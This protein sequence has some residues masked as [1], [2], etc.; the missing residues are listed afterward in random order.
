MSAIKLM[1]SHDRQT[2]RMS[3]RHPYC[4]G[5][6]C[7]T[8]GALQT[9]IAALG[10]ALAALC[11][12]ASGSANANEA[13]ARAGAPIKLANLT[14]PEA[15]FAH[16]C[17]TCH[18]RG[19]VAPT[20]SQ[21]SGL[22]EMQI[23]GALWQGVMQEPANGLDSGQRMLLAQW[24]S[25]LNPHKAQHGPGVKKCAT[26]DDDRW[27]ATPATDWPG[28]SHNDS[29]Q[30]YVADSAMTPD[31]VRHTRLEWAL[32]LPEA[33][34]FEG[35]GNPVSVVGDRVFL[36]NINHWVYAL[37][38]KTGCAE[39]TFRAEGAVRSN[40]AVENGVLVFGDTLANVYGLNART[41][42]LMWQ[43]R[44]DMQPSARV[45]GNVTLHDGVAYIPISALQEVWSMRGNIPCCSF[46]GSVV[47]LDAKTGHRLWKTYTIDRPLRYLGKAKNGINRYGPSG[48]PVWSGI[49][50]DD[51]LGVV[52]V[53]T[54]NQY[55]EPRV[56]ASDAVMALDMRTGKKRWVTSLAPRRMSDQDIYV[57]GCETWVN[58]SRP[59]CSPVNP[60][61]EGDRDLGAPAEITKL[62]DG[63]RLLLAATKDGVFYALN[64]STGTVK[65]RV[66][67]GEGGETGGVEY[68]FATDGRYAYV[69]VSDL[70]LN[71]SA[72]GSFTAIDLSSGK[73]A[74]RVKG[75]TN[76]CSGK[77]PLC[78]NAYLDS[79]TVAGQVVWVGNQDGILRAYDRRNG[80][81]VWSYDTARK[82][83]GVNGATG[84]GGSIATG[85]PAVS[86]RRV[87]VLSGWGVMNLGMPGNTLLSFEVPK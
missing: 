71:G 7:N 82:F 38:A 18:D 4:L 12:G 2:I 39:W 62:A 67:V 63:T 16:D 11:I 30:R 24:I 10:L 86:G 50:V 40:V 17:A 72:K 75:A 42:A 8:R 14:N 61:G 43:K 21:L 84:R 36:A 58:P 26:S 48:A 41:G 85:G 51:R 28:W 76:T 44:V 46:R 6:S 64:P 57:M 49:S 45:T 35:A 13:V 37:N 29:F 68:G 54:G 20:L 52:F 53:T 33:S 87:Y 5:A 47:A 66:R 15:L 73:I 70:Q 22:T 79:P 34:V 65:W 31:Q 56:K 74:W 55:T 1:H 60:K 83:I 59:E 32:P 19:F 23:Q 69:P 78:N 3:R 77:P 25:G 9:W 80:E 27:H 81:L